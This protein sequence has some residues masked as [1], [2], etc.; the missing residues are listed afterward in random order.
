MSIFNVKDFYARSPKLGYQFKVEFLINEII[1]GKIIPHDHTSYVSRK[2]STC[3]QSVTIPSI[4]IKST[5]YVGAFL[6]NSL[7]YD[8]SDMILSITFEESDDMIVNKLIMYLL[9]KQRPNYVSDEDED[10]VTYKRIDFLQNS[11]MNTYINRNDNLE[12]VNFL[13]IKVFEMDPG[14]NNSNNYTYSLVHIFRDCFVTKS[15]NVNMEYTES[16]KGV[17]INLD[18]GFRQYYIADSSTVFRGKGNIT[19]IFENGLEKNNSDSNIK[20]DLLEEFDYESKDLVQLNLEGTGEGTKNFELT[21]EEIENSYNEVQ[22]STNVEINKEAFAEMS[23]LNAELMKRAYSTFQNKLREAGFKVAVNDFN[24]G[25]HQA[26]FG[27]VKGAHPS[28][29]K[30]DGNY[31]KLKPDGT[32]VKV[33]SHNATKEDRDTI[34]R[35]AAESG[36]ILNWEKDEVRYGRTSLWGDMSLAEGYNMSR[37]GKSYEY[38]NFERW[39]T[40]GKIKDANSGSE[41]DFEIQ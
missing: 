31:G 23:R 38:I 5:P 22:S 34:D 36:L 6:Y 41:V 15:E 1:D 7:E 13:D 24:G 39:V 3:V 17:T 37:D 28:S 33:D 9:E 8:F 27:S 10:G 26:G 19:S 35:L 21:D 32:Y 11:Y 30:F 25:G 4:K 16:P 2:L 14:K 18:F 40:K 20:N 12:L 29:Q